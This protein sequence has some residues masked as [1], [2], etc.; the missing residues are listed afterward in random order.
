[1]Q[2]GITM[3]ARRHAVKVRS[4]NTLQMAGSI[5][6]MRLTQSAIHTPEWMMER[7]SQGEGKSLLGRH[8]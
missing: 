6:W 2:A 5:S 3:L 1:M 7:P 4:V 8:G